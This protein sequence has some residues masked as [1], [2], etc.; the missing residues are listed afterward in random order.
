M[1]AGTNTATV[2]LA[3]H[4]ACAASNPFRWDGICISFIFWL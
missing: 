1:L 3:E 4:R 2:R